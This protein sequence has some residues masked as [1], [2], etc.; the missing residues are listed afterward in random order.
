M[1]DGEIDDHS[2]MIRF[3]LY[4]C[5]VD[6]E[7][8]IETNSIFQRKGHSKKDWYDKQLDAY[9]E[10]FP[11]LIK[12]NPRY[13]TPEKIRN[14]SFVGDED[15]A[16]LEDLW[17]RNLFEKM[18][19]GA[20]ITHK[21]DNWRDTPGSDRIVEVLLADNPAPVYIQA[22]GGANTAA[23]AFYKLKTAYPDK[24]EEAVSKAIIYNIWYQDGAGTYIEHYH[25]L[26][27]MLYSAS[28]KGSWDYN[29]LP[30][31]EGFVNE[32]VKNNHGPLGAL[33]PQDYISE[34]DTPAFLFNI[35]AGLRNDEH[36][37]YGGWGGRFE[38]FAGA[39][40]TYIDAMEDG[41][42]WISLRRWIA[43]ANAD[44]HARLEWCVKSYDQANH[45][46]IVSP[47]I[48]LSL[49]AVP[50]ETLTLDALRTIDPDEDEVSHSWWHYHFSG[51][52]P[53]H[54][55]IEIQGSDGSK[56]SLT[57]PNDAAG[58]DL[59]IIL[60]VKD[61]GTPSLKSYHRLVIMVQSDD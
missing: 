21:P 44:F 1:T 7:A 24:Y 60:T 45:H 61:N 28:F 5:D 56:S 29:S 16:H 17:W 52:N 23:R 12:H 9:Q 34:G 18:I 14:L 46:P 49:T 11:N 47:E 48:P 54:S 13:P 32:Y 10:V 25:P 43:D 38:K 58:K 51:Q 57:I 59:H 31:T 22:W 4:T 35:A 39:P 20:P 30:E 55:E 50:G 3:L 40:N 26:V 6:L 42:K 36:P 2:S 19:P 37:T 15:E 27:K 41:D 53:Y 33:Y 8:I